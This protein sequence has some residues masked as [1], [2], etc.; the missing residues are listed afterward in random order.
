M[1]SVDAEAALLRGEG[2]ASEPKEGSI[3][4]FKEGS[5]RQAACRH[6]CSDLPT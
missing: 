6:E 4:G 1:P 3:E 2:E 5:V